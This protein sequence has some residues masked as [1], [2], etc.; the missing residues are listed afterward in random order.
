M[1]APGPSPPRS[2]PSTALVRERSELP[3]IS[4]RACRHDTTLPTSLPTTSN[5][6]LVDQPA[7]KCRPHVVTHPTKR[8]GTRRCPMR[9]GAPRPWSAYVRHDCH[10]Q[11]QDCTKLPT[12]RR[13]GVVC[14][15]SLQT[16]CLAQGRSN[17]ATCATGLVGTSI[18]RRNS[19]SPVA[20]LSLLSF[21]ISAPGTRRTTPYTATITT[22]LP[23][24]GNATMSGG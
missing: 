4:S 24:R 2:C 19:S 17:M 5:G 16:R 9:P 15:P 8:P 20:L 1:C 22:R 3:R 6:P 13:T 14:G 10:A 21:A 11:G 7:D 18:V 23:S 12:D